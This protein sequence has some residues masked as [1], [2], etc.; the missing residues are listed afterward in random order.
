MKIGF[1]GC[2]NMGGALA[3]TVAKN[4]GVS[5]LV[6]DYDKKKTEALQAV[7]PCTVAKA[8]EIASTADFIFLAVKPH[9]IE[10]LLGE[11]RDALAKNPAGVVVSIAAGVE[12]EKING[13]LPDG[14]AAI[15]MMPNT[16][17]ALGEGMTVYAKNGAVTEAREAEYLRFMAKTGKVDALPESLINAATAIMG[18]GPAFA[19]VFLEALAD[20]GVSC[21]LPRDKAAL[22][23]A[24]MLRGAAEMAL[25]SGKH[26]ER[27]K[28][29]VCSPGG[30]TIEGVGALERGA[31]RG[32][33]REAVTA[34][35]EKT[36][37][38]K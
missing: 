5:V 10:G 11:L 19:Y 37:K 17:A 34:A 23:A 4:E 13:A 30:S 36:K 25:T 33:T 27:L 20:G 8:E 12:L 2:G 22:Y 16:A 6:S 29:E 35:Y 1:I 26:P 15:R 21:G 38:L 3:T 14:Q 24:Q 32:V 18:C 7:I 31:F 9:Q 28:D